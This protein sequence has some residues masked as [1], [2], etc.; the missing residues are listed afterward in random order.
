MSVEYIWTAGC[1]LKGV[2][3]AQESGKVLSRIAQH[4]EITAQRVVVAAQPNDSPLH[5]AFE[6]DDK[7]AARLHREAQA[8]YVLRSIRVV[9]DGSDEPDFVF[10]SVHTEEVKGYV[11]KARMMEETELHA[12]ALADA[13][14][15]L[16]GLLKRYRE[17]KELEDVWQVI[18]ERVA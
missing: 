2:V 8:R 16:R 17:L 5:G 9:R 14:R 10:F 18:E 6:W 15:A 1:Q 13:E 7:E 4:G 12:A 11:T 3:D